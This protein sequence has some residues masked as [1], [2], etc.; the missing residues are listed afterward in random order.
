MSVV[1]YLRLTPKQEFV[2]EF[3]RYLEELSLLVHH[4]KGFIDVEVLCP[5]GNTTDYVLLS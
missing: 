2:E 5:E 1:S 3:Q 4:Q